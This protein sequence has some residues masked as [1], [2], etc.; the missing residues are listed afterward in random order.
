MHILWSAY[1]SFLIIYYFFL[2]IAVNETL[3][4]CDSCSE[5]SVCPEISLEKTNSEERLSSCVY[6]ANVS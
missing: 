2:Q 4:Y 6:V 1:N 5:E 3:E